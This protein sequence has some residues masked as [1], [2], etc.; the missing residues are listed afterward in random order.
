MLS[1]YDRE[2]RQGSEAMNCDDWVAATGQAFDR[3][4]TEEDLR[5]RLK[6][7]KDRSG[8]YKPGSEFLADRDIQEACRLQQELNRRGLV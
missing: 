3:A 8:S 2:G 7:L 4:M 6:L 5:A 1:V